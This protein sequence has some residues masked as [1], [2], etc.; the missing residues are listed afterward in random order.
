MA[1]GMYEQRV[2]DLQGLLTDSNIQLTRTVGR[3]G[4]APYQ[5]FYWAVCLAGK[6]TFLARSSQVSL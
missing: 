6:M 1:I 2:L 4:G 3:S 5:L